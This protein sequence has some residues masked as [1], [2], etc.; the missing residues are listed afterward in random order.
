M[1][2]SLRKSFQSKDSLQNIIELVTMAK[3][4]TLISVYD[5]YTFTDN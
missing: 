3:D 2:L 1:P 4:L 5:G